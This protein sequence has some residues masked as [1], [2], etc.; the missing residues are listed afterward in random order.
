MACR[1]TIREQIE[2]CA[3][4]WDEDIAAHDDGERVMLAFVKY[5][6]VPVAPD[7]AVLETYEDPTVRV[8]EDQPIGIVMGGRRKWQDDIGEVYRA[9]VAARELEEERKQ[10]DLDAVRAQMRADYIDAARDRVVV[11]PGGGGDRAWH[12]TGDVGGE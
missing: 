5:V 10:R 6:K 9:V 7:L 2:E 3:D 1:F 11:G 8:D 12:R 4:E